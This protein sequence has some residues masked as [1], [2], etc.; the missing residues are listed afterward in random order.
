MPVAAARARS[1]IRGFNRDDPSASARPRFFSSTD[2][3][4][5]SLSRG[6]VHP[7]IH[8]SV[9]PSSLS[10]F[11]AEPILVERDG[12]AV[13]A[14]R[15]GEREDVPG[16]APSDVLDAVQVVLGRVAGRTV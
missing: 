8:P 9:R 7:S 3:L 13:G 4:F 15:V 12:V 14:A 16:R 10:R 2:T 1:I 11:L 5:L 6:P